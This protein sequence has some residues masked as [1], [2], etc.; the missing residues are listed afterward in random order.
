MERLTV[1]VCVCACVHPRQPL[2]LTTYHVMS[3]LFCLCCGCDT[4]GVCETVPSFCEAHAS[5]LGCRSAERV[6]HATPNSISSRLIEHGSS[7]ANGLLNEKKQQT[8]EPLCFIFVIVLAL[9]LR[10]GMPKGKREKRKTVAG[11]IPDLGTVLLRQCQF[12]PG[13]VASFHSPKTCV[14]GTLRTCCWFNVCCCA[15][16]TAAAA[17]AALAPFH[18]TWHWPSFKFELPAI[19]HS[20]E[21]GKA[22]CPFC[23]VVILLNRFLVK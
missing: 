12:L 19:H 5:V 16:T 15:T 4:G 23:L 1:F 22:A 21:A 7:L 14:L 9:K 6:T 2:S 8:K 3:I 11:L 20:I 18:C 13:T 17:V 10:P